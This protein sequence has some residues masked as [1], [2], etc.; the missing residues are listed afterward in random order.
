MWYYKTQKGVIFVEKNIGSIIKQARLQKGYTQEA[1]AQLVGV[2]KSAVAKWENG[3]VSE[4]KRSNIGS[5][6][7][8]LAIDPV[9]LVSDSDAMNKEKPTVQDDGISEE[10]QE[11]IDRIKSLPEDKI[12]LLLQVAKSIE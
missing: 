12:Q 7:E 11:L 2:Q 9:L 3:R 6:S 5:L 8:V 10:M 1:L 4:I